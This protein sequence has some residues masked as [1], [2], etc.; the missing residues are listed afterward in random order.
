MADE[1]QAEVQLSMDAP[2]G[3]LSSPVS[4]T[5][6]GRRGRPK[7]QLDVQVLRKF[8]PLQGPTRLARNVGVCART[9]RRR[10]REIDLVPAGSP[11]FQLESGSWVR[12]PAQRKTSN[13]SDEDLDVHIRHMILLLGPFGRKMGRGIVAEAAMIV[14]RS[15]LQ[16]ALARVLNGTGP[17]HSLAIQRRVYNVAGPNSLTHHDGYHSRHQLLRVLSKLTE[18]TRIDCLEDSGACIHRWIFQTRHRD[19]SQL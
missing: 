10:A 14:T 18:T 16:A 19:Q 7:K 17:R 12:N 3:S 15:R 2:E 8:Y 6:N 13:V 5:P 9:V 4:S 11:V 1:L